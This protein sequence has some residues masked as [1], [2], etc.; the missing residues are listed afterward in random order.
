MSS[1]LIQLD[2]WKICQT[3]NVI[4]LENMTENT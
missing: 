2:N 3:K 4:I 1:R